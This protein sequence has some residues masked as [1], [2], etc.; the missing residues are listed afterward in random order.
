MRQSDSKR[1]CFNTAQS[2]LHSSQHA[3]KTARSTPN[4]TYAP[5]SALAAGTRVEQFVRAAN[6]SGATVLLTVPCIGFVAC[7]GGNSSAPCS[8]AKVWGFSAS[9]YGAV[10]LAPTPNECTGAGPGASWCAVDATSG[11]RADGSAFGPVDAADTS[12]AIG[13]E[14]VLAM[15]ARARSAAPVARVALDNEPMLWSA[16]HRDVRP[17]P[18]TYDALWS[19]TLEYASAI[20][21]AAPDVLIH[22]P[23]LWGYCAYIASAAD[24]YGCTCGPDC[25]A[26][27][28]VPLLQWYISQVVAHYNATGVQLIDVIDVHF[29]PQADRVWSAAE[30][31][32]TTALRLRS[33]RSWW[34]PTY[35]DESW[36]GVPIAL[37]PRLRGYIAAAGGAVLSRPLQLAVSE[38]SWGTDGIISSAIAHVEILGMMTT[39][40]ISY[41]ARWIAPVAGSVVESAFRLFVNFDGSGGRVSGRVLPVN[42]SDSSVVGAYAFYDDTGS[43]AFVVVLTNKGAKPASVAVSLPLPRLGAIGAAVCRAFGFDG[44]NHTLR[45]LAAPPVPCGSGAGPWYVLLSPWSARLLTVAATDIAAACPSGG[46]TIT[47]APA[48]PSPT[49]SAATPTHSAAPTKSSTSTPAPTKTSSRTV[50]V[51]KS[52]TH[53]ALSTKT[54]TRTAA[55]TK[56]STKT[57]S[58]TH[59]A[60]R[61][62]TATRS[63]SRK[64]KGT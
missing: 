6:A 49:R 33:L 63:T 43:G 57:S 4:P 10:G 62:P 30:D 28:S 52:T 29:Y 9:K 20:K 47:A 58:A 26:H 5:R 16:Q 27:G 61:S 35:V 40:G 46:A 44:A 59:S 7:P 37:V 54:T 19:F 38:Y 12:A 3:T 53:T 31:A 41:G 17:A 36:I 60:T 24:P 2:C 45:T 14:W 13:P 23:V 56:S 18:T 55:L 1:S 39:L 8:S 48:T 50:T 22:G 11:V 25:A 34:D 15:L 51:T 42:S 64:A 32:A 21:A